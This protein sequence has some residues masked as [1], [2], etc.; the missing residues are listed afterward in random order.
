[1][2]NAS[3]LLGKTM[4]ALDGEIGSVDDIYFDDQTW[5]V[6]YLVVDTGK[7]TA[8][9]KAPVPP[10][11]IVKPWHH[12]AVVRVNLT[13][14]EVRSLAAAEPS[15]D[16]GLRSANELGGYHVQAK[17]G[18]AGN[19]DDLLLDDELSR[20]LFLAVDMKGWLFGKKVLAGPSLISRVDPASS[21]VHV[22]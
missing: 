6:R 3:R 22:D 7:W 8:G 9:Q 15:R 18:N 12:E 13:M 5:S 1:M 11:A 10:E 21:A 16:S 2:N 17:D 20:I 19:V 14:E 4:V